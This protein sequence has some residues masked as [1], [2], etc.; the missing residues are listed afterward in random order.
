[1]AEAWG[2]FFNDKTAN[3]NILS[4]I[5][6]N[7]IIS[8]ICLD[9][10]LKRVEACLKFSGQQGKNPSVGRDFGLGRQGGRYN[11]NDIVRF[12]RPIIARMAVVTR[13]VV[14]NV[15][16]GGPQGGK[17]DAYPVGTG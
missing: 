7:S 2:F 11:C 4:P 13:A 10:Q 14:L 8:F 6:R 15:D 17:Q 5:R 3:K 9:R 1:V 12:P 16:V